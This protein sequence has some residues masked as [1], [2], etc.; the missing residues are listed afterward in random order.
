MASSAANWSQIKG[1]KQHNLALASGLGRL[2]APDNP[3]K[4]DTSFFHKLAKFPHQHAK[5]SETGVPGKDERELAGYKQYLPPYIPTKDGTVTAES[6]KFC[7]KERN[8]HALV[9]EGLEA[10]E[11]GFRMQACVAAAYHR[12]NPISKCNTMI[13]YL[14]ENPIDGDE[15]P[16]TDTICYEHKSTAV[17]KK[18][19]AGKLVTVIKK[20]PCPTPFYKD[21]VTLRNDTYKYLRAS[22]PLYLSDVPNS[23]LKS[24]IA[25]LERNKVPPLNETNKITSENRVKYSEIKEFIL[26]NLTVNTPGSYYYNSLICA[27]RNDG[28]GILAWCDDIEERVQSIINHGKEWS[29]IVD[30]EAV[31]KLWDWCGKEEKELIKKAYQAFDQA[32]SYITI[33]NEQKF[34]DLADTI[35]RIE[36]STWPTARFKSSMCVEGKRKLLYTFEQFKEKADELNK[37]MNKFKQLSQT[38]DEYK[39]N[40]PSNNKKRGRNTNPTSTTGTTPSEKPPTKKSKSPVCKLCMKAGLGI[41]AHRTEDCNADL[42]DKAIAAKKRK[43]LKAASA[44]LNSRKRTKYGVDESVDPSNRYPDGACNWCVAAARPPKLATNHKP[45]T[46]CLKR[47]GPVQ[48]LLGVTYREMIN[49]TSHDKLNQAISDYFKE[50][51]RRA[52]EAKKNAKGRKVKFKTPPKTNLTNY[53][54]PATDTAKTG[55]GRGKGRGRGAGRGRAHSHRGRARGRGR[56][57]GKQRKWAVPLDQLPIGSEV[58]TRLPEGITE[59]EISFFS[60]KTFDKNPNGG[61]ARGAAIQYLSQS[62]SNREN[63]RREY[64]EFEA[65]R[66][67]QKEKHTQSLI[68]YANTLDTTEPDVPNNTNSTFQN[69]TTSGPSAGNDIQVD[70]TSN[71]AEVRIHDTLTPLPFRLNPHNASGYDHTER[72]QIDTVT[73]KSHSGDRIDVPMEAWCP[74]SRNS[75]PIAKTCMTNNKSNQ[76]PSQSNTDKLLSETKGYRLLQTYVQYRDACGNIREGRVQLDTQSNCSYTLPSI[77]LPRDWRPYESKTVMGLKRETIHLGKPNTFTIMKNGTPIVI[78]TNEPHQGKLNGDCVALLGWEAIQALGID[79]NHAMKY[80]THQKVKFTNDTQTTVDKCKKL[81]LTFMADYAAPIT[82]VEMTPERFCLLSEK[83][84]GEYNRTHPHEYEMKA[85]NPHTLDINPALPEEI[86]ALILALIDQYRDVLAEYTNSLP[87]CM[88]GVKPH[89]FKLKPGA[90][91]I[92]VPKPR[93]GPAKSKLILEWLEWALSVGLV[94]KANTTSYASRLILA[95]KYKGNTPK[96]APPDGIRIAWAG[97]DVNDNLEKTVPTYPDAWEQLYKVAN[98]RYKFSADGLKQYWSIPLAEESRDITAFW[99]PRGLFRFTRLVMGTKNAATI[100]QNAY[101]HAMYAKLPA[102]SLENV[103][104]FADDFLGGEDTPEGLVRVFEDFLIMCRKAGITLN[105]A[106]LRIGYE[107]EQFFGLTVKNGKISPA[108]RNIDPV[109]NM[110]YP[111]NR[112]ELRSVMG[113]FNQ[114]SHFIKDYGKASSPAAVLNSLNSTKVPFIFTEKHEVAL[115]K[116]KN[117]ILSKDNKLYLYAPRNDLP[118]HL[119]TDGSE[120]GWGAVLFQI[121]DGKR[122][123]IKMWSK[124]WAT[125]AWMKKPPYH[126]EAKAWMN[127]MELALP[128]TLFNPFPLE[129]YTDH[130]PL[131]WVKHTSGKGPVSQFII[132]KLSEV[133]YKMHYIKGKDNVVA[134]ALSR[135]PMLGPKTLTRT[136]L[137]EALNVLLAALVDCPLDASN[138]WFDAG[139]DTKHLLH[140][141]FSWREAIHK[142]TNQKKIHMDHFSESTIR[143]VKYTFG[144]WTPPADKITQQC[145]AAY[146]KGT[147]FACLIPGDLIRHIPIT[148]DGKFNRD[149]RELINK[150]GM[151]S[152][153]DT[154]LVWLIHKASPVRQVFEGHRCVLQQLG[155]I[156]ETLDGERDRVTPEHDLQALTKHLKSTNLTPPVDM[157]RTRQEWIQQQAEH[158]IPLIYAGKANHTQ[159]GLWYVEDYPGGPHRIIVP[160]VLQVPLVEWKHHSMCHMGPKK[161]YHE[162]KKKFFWENMWSTCH[163]TCKLCELCALLKAKM[164]LAHKHFRAKLFVTPRTAYGSD[165]YGVKKNKAGYCCILGIIDL[166]TGELILKACTSESG[167]SVAHVLLYDV[168]LKKGVPLVFHTDAAKAFLGKAVKALAE[169]LG[170]Q[171]TSTLAHNPKSNA[172][173][174]RVWLFVGRALRSMTAEQYAEFHLMLPILESVWNNTPDSDTGVTPFEVERGMPK[175]TIAESLTQN[176]P[177]QGLPASTSDIRTIAASVHAYTEHLQNVKAVE[178]AQAALRLNEKGFS[179]HTYQVGDRVTFYLPP[180]QDQAQKL[181][182]YPKHLLQY[183]GPGELVQALSNNGTAWKIRWNGRTYHRNVMHMIPYRPDTVVQEEQRFIQDNSVTVGSYVAVMDDSEDDHYHIAQVIEM[184]DDLTTLHY[185]GTGSKTLRSAVWKPMYHNAI[186]GVGYKYFDQRT[187]DRDWKRLTGSIESRPIEDSLIILPNVG[188]NDRMRLSKDTQDIIKPFRQKHHVYKRTWH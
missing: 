81:A 181:G 154:G 119:E 124:K 64:L 169:V 151:I 84:V 77:G 4:I 118:L 150:S 123:V 68:D 94:E 54:Q 13:K 43:E 96:T 87:K 168:V 105:P 86:K 140:E 185:M 61:Q 130:S 176:P 11:R 184:T 9:L 115:Q 22:I 101:T 74:A 180:S 39:K 126:R 90:K 59:E 166:A 18:N 120:D 24:H 127:G 25:G 109:K 102:R 72:R 31:I 104:N 75:V 135:F 93:F 134:D 91:P 23:V 110:V 136:G 14:Q 49:N 158:R 78:D 6:V 66:I 187:M 95:P 186:T 50:R 16:E 106:K 103:A 139:K 167:A 117:H 131:K 121:V 99:T 178:R 19:S 46:C 92:P 76:L 137:K 82:P 125:E 170:I 179:K 149:V 52:R 60:H 111:T 83:I 116:L 10:L 27:R 163:T 107:Q 37:L 182:K 17:K 133:D 143:K 65:K 108:L 144:I 45:E 51:S 53:R 71:D 162:L 174:E 89:E 38:F 183:A 113:I 7:T 153:V 55:S 152:L 63:N 97:V 35:R 73:F 155:P 80:E 146:K 85:I 62:K 164:R 56:G 34:D 112:S 138:L 1:Q 129:C 161:V 79:I 114:F 175:R 21:Y 41:R 47:D 20:L 15:I 58:Y 29:K 40:N 160:R 172:K 5:S 12:T 32:V 44:G 188:F 157:C 26:N 8:T 145:L 42:R 156:R 48:T 70:L 142:S 165:F 36:R 30:R 141:I 147:P 128:F 173:M 67:A 2:T 98:K 148:P 3:F 69:V 28:V 100:S 57:R 177:A 159:D 122:H 33:V 171:Q 88:K 132:D